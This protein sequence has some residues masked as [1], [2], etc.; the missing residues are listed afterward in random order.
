MHGDR[1]QIYDTLR[2][3]FTPLS[4]M[5]YTCIACVLN[6][7]CLFLSDVNVSI[8][9]ASLLSPEVFKN[10]AHFSALFLRSTSR[11]CSTFYAGIYRN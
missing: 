4:I 2:E 6:A 9:V 11:Y 3:H 5:N 8:S 10:I 7:Y 1:L